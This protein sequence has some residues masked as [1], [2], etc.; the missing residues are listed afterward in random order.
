MRQTDACVWCSGHDRPLLIR[1]T[2]VQTSRRILSVADDPFSGVG[3]GLVAGG[4]KMLE[5]SGLFGN[6]QADAAS[7]QQVY[8]QAN[9]QMQAAQNAAAAQEAQEYNRQMVVQSQ[10]YNAQQADVARQFSAGQ[11]L[12]AESF[13]ADQSAINRQFQE[14]MSSTAY[15][16]SR[17][18][19]AAAGLNPILAAGAG[20]SSTPGGSSGSIGAVG[21]ASA[22]AGPGS[23]PMAS[24]GLVSGARP[25]DRAGLL[26][27]VLSSAFEAARLKPTIDNLRSTGKFTDASAD[28]QAASAEASRALAKKTGQDQVESEARTDNLR[29]EK[30]N[31]EA[32]QSEVSGLGFHA[33]V[34]HW[35]EKFKQLGSDSDA[36][37]PR[38]FV[39][40]GGIAYP[41]PNSHAVESSNSA[42]HYLN[43]LLGGGE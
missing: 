2:K 24:S 28:S 41:A 21:G 29:A 13:N 9:M 6:K 20:G 38:T 27:G 5:N 10:D 42:Q 3:T 7:Q 35:W 11:Q 34:E 32:K 40:A 1:G 39:K 16:R 43:N 22:S 31:I 25:N 8:G 37:R 30:A 15:Q 23:S 19:M 14:R 4:L 18:D 33:N 17:A 12:Q 36:Q 26:E